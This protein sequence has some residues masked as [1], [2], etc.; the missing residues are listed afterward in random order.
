L[1]NKSEISDDRDKK[2]NHHEFY[3]FLKWGDLH[4][5]FMIFV[6]SHHRLSDHDFMNLF[7][8]QDYQKVSPPLPF[9]GSHVVFANDTEWTHIADDFLYTLW[10]SSRTVDVIAK[11]STSYDVFRCSIAD[12]DNSFEFEYHQGGRVIR[13]FVFEHNIFNGTETV[14]VDTG[15]QLTGEPTI[16]SDLK[17]SAEKMFPTITQALGIVRVIDPLQNR[18][19]GKKAG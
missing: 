4:T 8:L 9:T 1:S 5:P 17:V 15:V 18:F 12:I 11:L 3:P 14:I 6:R 10:H 16:L 7:G 2:G 19:Y 13:K